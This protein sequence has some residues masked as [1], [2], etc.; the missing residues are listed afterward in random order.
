MGRL[1]ERH[2]RLEL[3]NGAGSEQG[4][5]GTCLRFPDSTTEETERHLGMGEI[6]VRCPQGVPARTPSSH[7]ATSRGPIVACHPSRPLAAAS[8]PLDRQAQEESS[9]GVAVW[10]VGRGRSPDP[11]TVLA[12]ELQSDV[13][14]LSWRPV[15]GRDLA[16]GCGT[17]VALWRVPP[18]PGAG[19]LAVEGP[20]L[21]WLAPAPA[22]A[23]TGQ[24][25]M[26]TWHP[27]GH[28]LAG[29]CRGVAGFQ[30][31]D[32]AT[33]R[34]TPVR[35]TSD[36]T[37]ALAWSPCGAYLFQGHAS[38]TLRLWETTAWTSQAWAY[39][40][41]HSVHSARAGPRPSP[42]VAAAWAPARLSAQGLMLVAHAGAPGSLTALH[43][44]GASAPSLEA[45]P[46]PVSLAWPA[47]GKEEV[48]GMAWNPDGQRLAVS[49]AAAGRPATIV[50]YAICCDPLVTTR[51]VGEVPSETEDDATPTSVAFVGLKGSGPNHPLLAIA[52]S[53]RI[54]LI[55]L[56]YA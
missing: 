54:A 53:S 10:R 22:L 32:V 29:V 27:E 33:G 34:A 25:N 31:W 49:L 56:E 41:S 40:G 6:E 2:G 24:V 43:M 30:V 14:A 26:L 28:L 13:A 55:P 1:R 4:E 3:A 9:S 44:T 7:T 15:G 16:V 20:V 39:G 52:R 46:M 35:A 21:T 42:V 18:D 36:P 47:D 45:Q 23:G 11:A 51:V 50:L 19:A 48:T 37:T 38:G 12:H 8:M 5:G 17:G